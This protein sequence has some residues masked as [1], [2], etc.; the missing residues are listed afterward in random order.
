MNAIEPPAIMGQHAEEVGEIMEDG[1]DGKA[2]AKP[3]RLV[4]LMGPSGAG[5]STL[6]AACKPATAIISSD[7]MR[8]MISDDP[9]DQSVSGLAFGLAYRLVSLRLAH[10]RSCLFDATLLRASTRRSLLRRAHRFAARAELWIF[11]VEEALLLQRRT[12]RSRIVPLEVVRRQYQDFRMALT[13]VHGEGWDLIRTIT[14]TT[15]LDAES[16]DFTT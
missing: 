1:A 7:Q 9:A 14:T 15:E 2:V 8:A 10:G 5:K 6:A 12:A 3:L 13:Q 16:C 4:C 11:A